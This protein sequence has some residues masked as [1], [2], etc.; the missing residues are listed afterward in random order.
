MA[1]EHH[2][3]IGPSTRRPSNTGLLAVLVESDGTGS[4]SFEWP[5]VLDALTRGLE[6]IVRGALGGD[7]SVIGVRF[8]DADGRAVTGPAPGSLTLIGFTTTQRPK[9]T[10]T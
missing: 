7:V 2:P 1:A 8:I 6:H 4:A 10:V 5:S 3:T 9:E